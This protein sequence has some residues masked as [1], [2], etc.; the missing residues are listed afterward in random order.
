[1]SFHL[2]NVSELLPMVA[3]YYA[4]LAKLEL[5]LPESPSLYGVRLVLATKDI[6]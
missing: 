1:M 2:T 4:I 5:Q 6:L 3:L